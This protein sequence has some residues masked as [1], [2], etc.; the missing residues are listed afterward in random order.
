MKQ[1]CSDSIKKKITIVS[2]GA[3][4]Y[5]KYR[6]QLFELTRAPYDIKWFF[7][8]TGHGNGAVDG[9]GGLIKHYATSRNL[10]EPHEKS[11]QNVNDF[12]EHVKK[13]ANAIKII[14]LQDVDV[15]EFRKV[16]K[17]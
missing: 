11:I 14:R 1:N 15:E 17:C 9:V 10:R 6:F 4:S 13:Y 7:S 16:K 3:A 2:D 5:F 12:V 8:A